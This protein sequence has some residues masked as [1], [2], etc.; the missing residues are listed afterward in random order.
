MTG[1]GR[2]IT[3]HTPLGAAQLNPMVD[4]CNAFLGMRVTGGS[5]S[6]H[7]DMATLTIDPQGTGDGGPAPRFPFAVFNASEGNNLFVRVRPGRVNGIMPTIGGTALTASPKLSVNVS[8]MV[9]LRATL[10]DNF[11]LVSVEVHTAATLPAPDYAHPAIAIADVEIETGGDVNRLQIR[12]GLFSDLQLIRFY[13]DFVWVPFNAGK[14][15]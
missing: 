4:A 7:G 14:V 11:D 13:S 12:Q 5:F 3:G 15:S 8:G 6:V 10:D 2:F 9:Y 1:I